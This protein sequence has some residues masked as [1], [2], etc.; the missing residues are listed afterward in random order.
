[1]K[2]AK[3]LSAPKEPEKNIKHQVVQ[4]FQ[5]LMGALDLKKIE[6]DHKHAC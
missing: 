4:S 2:H 5:I 6:E 1:M 3:L